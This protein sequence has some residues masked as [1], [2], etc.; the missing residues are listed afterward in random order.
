MSSSE[1]TLPRIAPIAPARRTAHS[2]SP[3]NPAT[4]KKATATPAPV[5][6]RITLRPS[7]LK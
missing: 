6:Q 2:G 3:I 5:P 7:I 1:R 4:T